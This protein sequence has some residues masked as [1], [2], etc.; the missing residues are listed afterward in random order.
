[1]SQRHFF[2]TKY[3]DDETMSTICIKNETGRFFNVV[4][5]GEF[6]ILDSPGYENI[7]LEFF[8]TLHAKLYKLYEMGS[9]TSTRIITFLMYNENH[10]LHIEIVAQILCLPTERLGDVPNSFYTSQFWRSI[11]RE[12]MYDPTNAKAWLI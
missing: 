12:T 2:P 1:M 7:T 8:S 10:E 4:V 9:L 11:S 5:L 3:I 6:D